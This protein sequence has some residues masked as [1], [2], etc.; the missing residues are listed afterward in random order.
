MEAVN[1]VIYDAVLLKDAAATYIYGGEDLKRAKYV[2]VAKAASGRLDDAW[3]FWNGEGWTVD[4]LA[5][6]RLF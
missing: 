3:E 6:K 4:P 2:H 1:R 5:S